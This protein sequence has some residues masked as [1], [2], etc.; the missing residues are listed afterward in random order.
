MRFSVDCIA[1]LDI[2]FVGSGFKRDDGNKRRYYRCRSGGSSNRFRLD[3]WRIRFLWFHY[4]RNLY[5]AGP[6]AKPWWHQ[7][8]SHFKRIGGAQR[9]SITR[10]PG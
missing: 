8:R 6:R 3:D 2:G 5:S 7:R 1:A 10:P 4:R 9:E